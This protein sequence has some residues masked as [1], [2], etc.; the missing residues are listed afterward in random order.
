[1]RLKNALTAGVFALAAS[2]FAVP[3]S[4]TVVF[5][6]TGTGEN[7]GAVSGSASFTLAGNILTLILTNTSANPTPAQGNTLTGLVFS[8]NGSGQALSFAMS[9]AGCGP[10]LGAGSHLFTSATATNDGASL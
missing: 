4:A 1:M 7:P 6:G 9:G 5:T 8:I 3:A 2:I 10:T